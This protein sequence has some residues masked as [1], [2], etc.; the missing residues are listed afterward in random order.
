MWRSFCW[1]LGPLACSYYLSDVR[2][3]GCLDEKTFL[4]SFRFSVWQKKVHFDRLPW[5]AK[6]DWRSHNHKTNR[7]NVT[8]TYRINFTIEAFNLSRFV[9][10]CLSHSRRIQPISSSVHHIHYWPLLVNIGFKPSAH[11]SRVDSQNSPRRS[12]SGRHYVISLL[13]TNKRNRQPI[14]IVA[15]PAPLFVL[16]KSAGCRIRG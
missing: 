16:V 5:N 11:Q 12:R 8:P 15:Q 2:L 14:R 3:G 9:P 7:H 13:F 4:W 6:H 10:Q 1:V